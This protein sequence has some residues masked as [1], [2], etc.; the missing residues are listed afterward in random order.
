MKGKAKPW[1]WPTEVEPRRQTDEGD[2]PNLE[3]QDGAADS[4]DRGGYGG[5]TDWGD[6]GG[7]ENG[8]S[9]DDRESEG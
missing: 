4:Q 3:A 1:D 7:S 2:I 5:S 9:E 6:D 8:E